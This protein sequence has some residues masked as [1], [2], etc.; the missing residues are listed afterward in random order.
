MAAR[1]AA[2]IDTTFASHYQQ[3]VGLAEALRPEAVMVYG[4]QATG[5]KVLIEPQR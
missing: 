1:V 4:Q 2:E 3:R 5:K